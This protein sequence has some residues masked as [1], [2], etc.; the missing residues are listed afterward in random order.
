MYYPGFDLVTMTVPKMPLFQENACFLLIVSSE[1]AASKRWLWSIFSLHFLSWFISGMSLKC[2]FIKS[3][4]W[5]EYIHIQTQPPNADFHPWQASG[6]SCSQIWS[7]IF[8][9]NIR[10]LRGRGWGV[11][12]ASKNLKVNRENEIVFFFR[13]LLCK[14][15]IWIISHLT[16]PGSRCASF[17]NAGSYPWYCILSI[18][19][20]PWEASWDS[21]KDFGLEIRLGPLFCSHY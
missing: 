9:K 20:S 17:H 5:W 10:A 13:I 12:V 2:G 4:H 8:N 16:I 11:E 14:Q 3:F 21:R 19:C 1:D 15:I 7:C 18:Y 6:A